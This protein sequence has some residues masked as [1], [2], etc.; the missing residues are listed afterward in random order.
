MDCMSALI[1]YL[2]PSRLARDCKESKCRGWNGGS[3]SGRLRRGED[4]PGIEPSAQGFAEFPG[5]LLHLLL[6]F[7]HFAAGDFLLAG[8]DGAVFD[9]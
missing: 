9:Q 3:S 7:S 4:L 1:N 8:E 5:G 6:E 2:I